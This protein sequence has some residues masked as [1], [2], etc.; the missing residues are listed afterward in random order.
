MSAIGNYV[1]YSY[2]NYE[3]FGITQDETVKNAPR[4]AQ[5]IFTQQKKDAMQ[6]VLGQ[7][8]PTQK[9]ESLSNFLTQLIYNSD[10][11]SKQDEK[12]YKRLQKLLDEK[13]HEKYTRFGIGKNLGVYAQGGKIKA[14]KITKNNAEKYV[15]TLNNIL[16]KI[17]GE[18]N[19][20]EAD[21]DL[22]TKTIN[23]LKLEV[24]KISDKEVITNKNLIEDI[25]TCLNLD[26]LPY[27]QAT[28][29]V[30]EQALAILSLLM[31]KKADSE[32]PGLIDGLV[33]GAERSD[34][35]IY[36]N[37]FS[38]DFVDL[39]TVLNHKKKL[40]ENN[41]YSFGATQDKLDVMFH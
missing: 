16:L 3:K 17:S 8:T 7:N 29:D 24:N 5:K 12:I 39:N 14:E 25:N 30:F 13:F 33:K 6:R 10:H 36:K 21:R 31:D 27:A 40:D 1:H 19:I 22:L 18:T 26:T 37:N 11:L 4:I 35:K 20:N 9:L 23:N 34:V 32:I 2:S 41:S 38:N 28:G 15:N